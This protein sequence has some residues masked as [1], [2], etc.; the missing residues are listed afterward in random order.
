MQNFLTTIK[1]GTFL[2]TRQLRRANIW[3]TLLIVFIM[4]LTFLNMVVVSGILVGLID[5][6]NIANRK[7]YTGN[8]ILTKLSGDPYIE[9]T[10]NIL[11][12]IPTIPGV[13]KWNERYSTGAQFEA[14]YLTRRDFNTERDTVG[15]SLLGIDV[16]QE[17]DLTN[18]SKYVLEGEYLD[19]NESGYILMGSTLLRRFSS[20]FGDGFGSLDGVYPGD[21]VKVTSNGKTKEFIV[22]GIVKSKVGE[23]SFR[24]FITKQDFLQFVERPS[25]NADEIAI[26]TDGS[27][28]DDALKST[29]VN[30]GFDRFGLIQTATEAIPDF[31]NQIKL[32]FG[33]LGNVIGF[34]GIVV[35]SIT[36]FI[37]IFINAVTRRKYIGILKGIGVTSGAIEFSY[38]LQSFVYAVIGAG[39]GM[40]LI[41]TVFVPLLN[42][43]PLDFPFSD[44]IL[45]AP[46]GG[47]MIRFFL[48]LIV[49]LFAGYIP[50]R[51]IVKKNT[52]DSILGR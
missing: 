32:A 27:I 11:A 28:T 1:V 35:A 36:I 44:G 20:A 17:D 37:V 14:N 12:T 47:T 24:A 9:N 51:M 19:P 49:T 18:L 7:Q 30:Y 39:L 50:A 25:L 34:I 21:R 10:Q 8:V 31:L 43:H 42:A 3:T 46:I 29:L 26:A 52:L 15:S 48:L 4:M 40:L 16:K 6:G 22:K 2:G 38:V 5:G 23:V 33:L 13:T 41:Y 45:S